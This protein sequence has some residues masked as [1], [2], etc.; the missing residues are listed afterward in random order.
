MK[1]MLC[2]LLSLFV[3]SAYAEN[4]DELEA[5]ELT[6]KAWSAAGKNDHKKVIEYTDLCINKWLTEAKK[7]QTS[8]KSL[9]E[10]TEEEV[11][12]YAAL[13]EVG[14]CLFIKGESQLKNGDKKGALKTFQLLLKMFVMKNQVL[15]L[16]KYL[17][18]CLSLL[19][20]TI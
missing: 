11:N 20:L 13:N 19:M 9:P 12:E 1:S 18:I 4:L 17:R 7:M 5:Y 8:L 6:A 10:G 15:L 16:G 14:T 3:I 2:V